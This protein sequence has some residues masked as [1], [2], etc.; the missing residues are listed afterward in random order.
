M[1][2][3]ESWLDPEEMTEDVGENVDGNSEPMSV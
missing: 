1:T 3:E 2:V